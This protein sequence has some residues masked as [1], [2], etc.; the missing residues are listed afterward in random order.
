[1]ALFMS[2]NGVEVVLPQV[3]MFVVMVLGALALAI[4][5][6]GKMKTPAAPA[7]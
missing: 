6:Y 1:M 4:M 2:L 5:F 3:I 7:A